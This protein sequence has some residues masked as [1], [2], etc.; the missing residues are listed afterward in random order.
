MADPFDSILGQ[1]RVRDFLRASVAAGRVSHAYLFAGIPGSNKTTAAYAL[2]QALVC[3]QGGCEKCD[4]CRRIR[5]QSHPDVHFYIPEGANGYLINQIRELTADIMRAPIRAKTKV[6]IIDR[7]DMLGTAAAN[8]FLK[9]LEEPPKNVVMILLGHSCEAVLPTIGSRCQ[10]VAFPAIP[11]NEALG[12]VCQNSGIP[13]ERARIALAACDGSITK[14]IAFCKNNEGFEYR[15]LV[16]Q[17]LSSLK[18]ADD[19]DVLCLSRTLIQKAQAALDTFREAQEEQLAQHAEFLA[20]PAVKQI[21]ERNKRILAAHS[22][23]LLHRMYSIIK[24]W[25]RD[26]VALCGGASHVVINE[27]VYTLL[28]TTARHITLARALGALDAI[29]RADEA[30]AYNVSPQTCTDALLLELREV[31]Y[32]PDS[33]GTSCLQSKNTVVRCM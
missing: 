20:A 13:R 26:L 7:V 18:H 10:V 22:S 19:W 33:T 1:P 29:Q 21:T 27:D 4:D 12:I 32:D 17:A 25:V 23:E 11:E 28:E 15:T 3:L 9:S 5:R 14:A 31:L 30:I 2:A 8:A 16:L 24:S 6:Y